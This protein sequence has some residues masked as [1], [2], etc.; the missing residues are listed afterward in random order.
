MA[1]GPVFFCATLFI[2]TNVFGTAHHYIL[3]STT[4][5]RDN[6]LVIILRGVCVCVYIKLW[7]A[8]GSYVCVCDDEASAYSLSA[9][10]N[11]IFSTRRFFA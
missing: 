10:H 9:H 5:G 1:G 2:R 6:K 7:I 8:Q 4:G 11:S 3:A